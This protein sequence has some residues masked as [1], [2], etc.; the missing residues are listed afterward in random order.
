MWNFNCHHSLRDSKGTFDLT[1]RKYLI[2]LSP[3]T[4]FLSMTLKRQLFSIAPL[5]VAPLPPLLPSLAPGRCLRTSA[6]ITYQFYFL[7]FFLQY[8]APTNVPL[9]SI[10]RKLAGM[11]L[12]FTLTFTVLLERNIRLFPLLL[13]SSLLWH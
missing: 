11:T 5:A 7:S 4:S 12:P 2:G 13:L 3:L 1:G 8:F 6:L 9:P 10:F